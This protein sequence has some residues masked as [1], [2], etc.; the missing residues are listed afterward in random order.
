MNRVNSCSGYSRDDSTLNTDL[1]VILTRV[2]KEG[3]KKLGKKEKLERLMLQA[4]VELKT[5]V[6]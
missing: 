5:I 3:G 4:I 6:Q 2:K 1:I